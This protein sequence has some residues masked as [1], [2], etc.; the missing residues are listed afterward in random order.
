MEHTQQQKD[1]SQNKYILYARKSTESEDRQVASIESQIEA[2][3]EVAKE[4]NLNIVEI[5]SESASGF[6]IG[7]P[8]FNQM[9]DKLLKGEAN[10]IISWK[11]SRLSRNPDDAGKLMGMLQRG[12]ISHI[13]TV[14]RNWYPEDNVMMMY[15]EFGVNNQ[16]SRDLSLDTHRGLKKKA[17]RG[18]S[19]VS[20]LPLGYL[21]S[22]FKKLGD[23]EIICDTE[24]FSIVQKGLKIIATRRMTPRETLKY[25]HENGFR[26]RRGKKVAYSVFYRM[27]TN[28]FYYGKFEYPI[29]SNNWFDGKHTKAITEDEFESIQIFL[30]R[31]DRPRPKKWFFAYTGMM[32]CGECGASIIADA[33]RKTQKNGNRHEYTYYRCSKNKGHCTQRSMEVKTIDKRFSEIISKIKIPEEFH[34]WAIEELKK[35]HDKETTD[36]TSMLKSTWTLYNECIK[37]IDDLVE[38]MIDGK[39]PEDSYQ[40][41]LKMYEAERKKLKKILDN[42]D[43]R[44]K[45]WTNKA[46][47]ILD[48]ALTAK[49][50]FENGDD[51]K[52]K[53][54]VTFLGSNLIMKDGNLTIEVQKPLE[55]VSELVP[56]INSIIEKFEP[57]N[58]IKNKEDL[59][60]FLSNDS[61][62]GSRW[63]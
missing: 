63:K 62:W 10:G 28:P 58:N 21:H 24:R 59:K 53:E 54:I 4:L 33:K 29:G 37:K 49:E 1:L 5:L 7:R 22:P 48:F 26:T 16:F 36:R 60:I 12:E 19:P 18:W 17:N 40:R 3:Q 14:D 50:K 31:K 13:R 6:H 45:E 11:L 27:L 44:I 2:M 61:K 34:E 8:V 35:D 52:K 56:E 47:E 42:S 39:I 9:I 46:E 38:G 25:M 51:S 55:I 15:V 30:G 43:K 20:N 41:K 32:K 23:E 57:L